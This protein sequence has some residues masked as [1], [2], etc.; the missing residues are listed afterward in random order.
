MW[1]EIT[2]ITGVMN[3]TKMKSKLGAKITVLI[4]A[5][6]K[7]ML[8]QVL[9]KFVSTNQA[10]RSFRRRSTQCFNGIIKRLFVMHTCPM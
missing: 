2:Q 3:N 8:S 10:V 1:F 4:K 5:H 7:S 9:Y 6:T